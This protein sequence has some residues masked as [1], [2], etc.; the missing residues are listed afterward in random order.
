MTQSSG[1]SRD[2]HSCPERVIPLWDD[3]AHLASVMT[4]YAVTSRDTYTKMQKKFSK[5]FLN[6]L[7]KRNKEKW[8]QNKKYTDCKPN[9]Y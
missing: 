6:N 3:S 8:C 5:S 7:C 2:A 1:T 4:R 9:V